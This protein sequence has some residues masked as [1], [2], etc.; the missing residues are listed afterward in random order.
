MAEPLDGLTFY[1][2]AHGNTIHVRDLRGGHH[3]IV[4]RLGRYVATAQTT[5]SPWYG[6][7]EWRGDRY[8]RSQLPDMKALFATTVPGEV[9][10]SPW[11]PLP[12]DRATTRRTPNQGMTADMALRFPHLVP[13]V[14]ATTYAHALG[15]QGSYEWCHLIAHSMRGQDG[16][17]NVVAGTSHNNS[18]QLV[19]ENLLSCYRREWGIEMR[20]SARVRDAGVGRRL[21]LAIRYEV[22]I[23]GATRTMYLDCQTQRAPSGI[24]VEV[25]MEG[26]ARWINLSLRQRVPASP[27][28]Q[29]I[30]QVLEDCPQFAKPR[31]KRDRNDDLGN[32]NA[33]LDK[34]RKRARR[35]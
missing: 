6:R 9:A 35:E 20:V 21:G 32:T 5:S 13:P 16:P 17:A 4:S 7:I 30:R 11:V 28:P 34:R 33:A 31:L 19:V 27:T 3:T 10:P 25:M 8:T 1:R 29:Q 12:P 23:D 15:L 22:R 2:R 26:L 24:H 14:S 18:E